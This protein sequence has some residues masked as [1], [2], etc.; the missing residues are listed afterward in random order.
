MNDFAKEWPTHSRSKKNLM[1]INLNV[2]VR[3]GFNADADP[4]FHLNADPD[5]GS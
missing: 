1:I 3:S 4:V 2:V 5:P